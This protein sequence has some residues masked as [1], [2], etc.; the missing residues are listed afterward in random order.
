MA[1]PVLVF[2]RLLAAALLLAFFSSPEDV[3]WS[4]S[5]PQQCSL[6]GPESTSASSQEQGGQKQ[7]SQ[8]QISDL[9]QRVEA[10]P[11]YKRMLQQLGK[12]QSCTV[13]QEGDSI[14]LS[15]AFRKSARLDV[16]AN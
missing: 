12:P 8:K 5:T 2:A 10:G 4:Q 7:T 13:K 11:F 9:R 3:S 6:A 1:R 14:A 16:Q 15:Y